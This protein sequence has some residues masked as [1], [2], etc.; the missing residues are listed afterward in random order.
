MRRVNV[1]ILLDLDKP[2]D[3]AVMA[4]LDGIKDERGLTGRAPTLRCLIVDEAR[5][6]GMLDPVEPVPGAQS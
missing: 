1:N 5:R 2:R 6:R 4:A 3:A